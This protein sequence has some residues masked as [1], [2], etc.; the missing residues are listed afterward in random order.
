MHAAKLSFP[1]ERSVASVNSLAIPSASVTVQ[2]VLGFVDGG[3]VSVLGV[4]LLATRRH[5]QKYPQRAIAAK[6]GATE[7]NTWIGRE[8]AQK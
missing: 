7:S 1:C 4:L 6:Q 8:S 2:Q 3:G 5:G